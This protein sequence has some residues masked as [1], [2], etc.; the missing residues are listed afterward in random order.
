MNSSRE[1]LTQFS[2]CWWW[3]WCLDQ[4]VVCVNWWS[5]QFMAIS[6]LFVYFTKTRKSTQLNWAR[7]IRTIRNLSLYDVRP[8]WLIW[9]R[10][11][12][13][14]FLFFSTCRGTNGEEPIVRSDHVSNRPIRFL[15]LLLF[16]D[17]SKVT[18]G[19][20]T[21][22]KTLTHIHILIVLLIYLQ[23]L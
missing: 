8:L 14:C 9:D 12:S 2:W 20:T 5:M 16:I 7:Q 21:I 18:S 13:C 3:W 19:S 17:D 4:I 11:E 22:Y 15:L 1:Q 10:H 23:M 6:C